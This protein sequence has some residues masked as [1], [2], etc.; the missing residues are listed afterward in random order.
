MGTSGDMIVS[1]Q[2]RA[3]VSSRGARAVRARTVQ[4]T[5]QRRALERRRTNG[6]LQ[7]GLEDLVLRELLHV[8]RQPYL[9][10][11]PPLRQDELRIEH[12]AG[13]GGQD[14]TA[15][16]ERRQRAQITR[17]RGCWCAGARRAAPVGMGMGTPPRTRLLLPAWT[18]PL[19][20]AP[21]FDFSNNESTDFKGFS[22]NREE[23]WG[24]IQ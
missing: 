19:G 20:S 18:Q 12:G 23:R 6:L 8:G 2:A 24:T 13:R 21:F 22:E 16:C 10:E 1:A 5:V 9:A 4:R 14:G 11:R 3:A 7:V 15:P 17:V